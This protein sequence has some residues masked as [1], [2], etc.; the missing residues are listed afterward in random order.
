MAIE[1]YKSPQPTTSVSNEEANS[2]ILHK[3]EHFPVISSNS[4]ITEENESSQPSNEKI[5]ANSK[6]STI[7]VANSSIL[8]T[9][10]HL[11][12]N[13]FISSSRITTE[14]NESSQPSN[15]KIGATSKSS[16]SDVELQENRYPSFYGMERREANSM[17]EDFQ[18]HRYPSFYVDVEND[19]PQRGKSKTNVEIDLQDNEYHSNNE[20]CAF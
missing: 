11:H 1:N 4:F 20:V 16:T 2:S 3:E 8:H 5:G 7:D 9:E 12:D 14:E 15:E 13:P 10:E 6:S 19:I 17:D 18:K